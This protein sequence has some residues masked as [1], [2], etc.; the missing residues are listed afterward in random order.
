MVAILFRPFSAGKWFMIAFSAWLAGL[1]DRSN[2]AGSA[3]LGEDR[4]SIAEGLGDAALSL[5]EGMIWILVAGALLAASLVLLVVLLWVSSRAKF[6]FLDNVLHNRG[7]ITEPWGR[8]TRL[9]DSL[10]L[11]L[12]GLNLIVL[13]LAVAA[14][15]IL[16]LLVG[17]DAVANLGGALPLAGVIY[18]VL[19][20]LAL[21]IP[22]LYLYLFL[23]DFIVPIMTRF[24]MSTSAAWRRFLLLLKTHPLEFLFYGF[25][26]LVLYVLVAMAAV[27]VT[28]LTCCVGGILL[29]L[30]YLG[31]VVLL[32]VLVLHRL[33]GLEFLAQFGPEYE[34]LPPLPPPPPA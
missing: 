34:L 31:T 23:D 4:E 32:P 5:Q 10:F 7:R 17:I 22:L 26:I 19:L 8:F 29:A 14:V 24:N 9:G 27:A 13:V 15:G 25:C 28:I 33:Y 20:G 12:L 6:I 16:I 30:P 21:V 3:N 11:W 2:L 18:L 1:L